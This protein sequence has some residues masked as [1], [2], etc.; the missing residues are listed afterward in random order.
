[1][2]DVEV[3]AMEAAVITQLVKD[4]VPFAEA[5][6]QVL[7][8][9]TEKA[10]PEPEI[11]I[12]PPVI[13]QKSKDFSN[14]QRKLFDVLE[15]IDDQ[16]AYEIYAESVP[17]Y[18]MDWVLRK[19]LQEAHKRNN[20]NFL[21]ADFIILLLKEQRAIDPTKGGKVQSSSSGPK[22]TYNP[23]TGNWS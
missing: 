15:N 7:G 2:E 17:S 12:E 11:D 19:T 5:R 22:D 23:V 13:P 20:P 6:A 18:L 8:G 14:E 3:D 10:E 1:M 16:E 4:G 9:D 21:V